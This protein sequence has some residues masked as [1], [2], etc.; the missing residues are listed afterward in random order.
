MQFRQYRGQRGAVASVGVEQLLQACGLLQGRLQGRGGGGGGGGALVQQVFLDGLGFGVFDAP[1]LVA[2]SK[3]AKGQ[4]EDAFEKVK[5][6]KDCASEW[7][8]EVPGEEVATLG[9]GG[10]GG[11]VI[12][13]CV[14]R[15]R[16]SLA[17]VH[18]GRLLTGTAATRRHWG[19]AHGCCGVSVGVGL[20]LLDTD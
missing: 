18:V 1:L 3:V 16:C 4:D 19:V 2:T 6:Q 5:H 8:V 10:G 12:G 15:G 11:G 14:G 9:G 20:G 7:H 13:R 17:T